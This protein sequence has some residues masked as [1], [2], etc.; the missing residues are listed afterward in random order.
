VNLPYWPR[1]VCASLAVFFLL[2]GAL[3]AA[4]S[5]VAEMSIRAVGR[6]KAARAARMLFVLRM[7]PCGV[8]ALVVTCLCVPSYMWLEPA[9]VSERVGVWCLGAALAGAGV[10][11]ASAARA[12]GALV[13]SW[14]YVRYF[15]AQG[16]EV[17]VA[18]DGAPVWVVERGA[19]PVAL[20]GTVRP[21][22]VVSEAVLGALSSAELSAALR[23]ERAHAAARDNLKR[24]CL[25]LA[26]GCLPGWRGLGKVERAWRRF[27]EWAADDSAA[28][29]DERQS[30]C[31]AAAL[32]RVSRMN[33]GA[34]PPV[35]ASSLLGDGS[36]LQ[37]RVE[38]L[39]SGVPHESA[40]GRGWR[41]A[42]AGAAMMAAAM[43]QPVTLRLAHRLME[44]L[45]E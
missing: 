20:A 4:V 39:L 19:P 37:A 1:L 23:H 38:R 27:A 26:P 2:N 6:M 45:I 3:G 11:A 13:R 28:A 21:R 22:V 5:L 41:M 14:A 40:R 15:R 32:V 17:M 44:M 24:L 18:E 34:R 36:D 25:L 33:A 43:L 16:R 31:L 42:C 30:L 29:R 35:L 8:S 7:V 9:G 12:W 10:W